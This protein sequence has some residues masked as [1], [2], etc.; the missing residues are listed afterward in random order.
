MTIHDNYVEYV[1]DLQVFMYG[2]YMFYSDASYCGRLLTLLLQTQELI[3]ISGIA[4]IPVVLLLIGLREI[5]MCTL[6]TIMIML[7]E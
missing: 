3:N 7:H 2:R 1:K 4:R 5:R 6:G